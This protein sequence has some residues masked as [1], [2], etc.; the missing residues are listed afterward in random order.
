MKSIFLL[1]YHPLCPYSKLCLDILSKIDF[2]VEII[3]ICD[4]FNPSFVSHV[5]ALVYPGHVFVGK[6]LFDLLEK[7]IMLYDCVKQTDK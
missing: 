6:E 4:G 2:C 1:Y 3:N 5:P 7:R